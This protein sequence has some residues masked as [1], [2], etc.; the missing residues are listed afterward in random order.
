L[1]RIRRPSQAPA[2]AESPYRGPLLGADALEA[3]ARAL[4]AR[5]TLARRTRKGARRF[6]SRLNE[7]CKVLRQ[8]YQAVAEDV[9][10]GRAILPAAEWLLDNFHLIESQELEVRHNLP[11]SYYLELPKLA[12][13]DYGGAARIY[14][15]ALELIGHSDG[16]LNLDRL[17]RFVA[18]FQTL[19][20]LTIG[21]LWAWPSMLRI[22]LLENL[23]RLADEILQSRA[24]RRQADLFLSEW[25]RREESGKTPVLPEKPP[26]AYVVQLLRHLRE[27][28]SDA[29]ELRRL[30]DEKLVLHDLSPEDAIRAEHQEQATALAAMANTVTSLRFC[31]TLDWSLYFER[32]SLVEQILHR[33][34]AAVYK[35]MDF[36]TRD[37]YRQAVEDLAEPSGEAQV[38]VALRAIESAVLAQERDPSDDRARHVGFHLLGKGRRK[39][40]NDVAYQPALGRRMAAFVFAHATAIYLSAIG[41]L[42]LLAALGAAWA[43]RGAGLAVMAALLAVFPA[44]DLAVSIVQW[45]VTKMIR[46]R[47]LPRLD[48]AGGVPPEGRTMVIIPTLLTS[49]DDVQ[50]LLEH[51]EVQAIGNMDPHIHFAILSDFVDAP[52]A[53]TP[54]DAPILDAARKGIGSLNLRLGNGKNDRFFLFH[55]ARLWNPKE[56]RWM[57]WERKRGKIEEFNRLLRGAGDTSYSTQEGDGSILPQIRFCITLDRDTRL[58][59]DTAKQLIGII[60]HP[61]NRPKLD[62]AQG[63]ITEG[64]GI[65]QPRVSVTFASA[66]GS[67]FSR[68]Y[69]GHTGVD[70]YTTAVS[71]TYQDLFGEGIYTGKGLYDVDAFLAALGDRIPENA[72]L[73]HDLFE[74]LYARTALAS[75]IEVVDDYPSSVVAHMRRQHRWVRGDW[76]ILLWLFPWVPTRRGVERNRLPIISRWK[77]FDNLRRSLVS[78]LMVL[79]LAAGWMIFPGPAWAWTLAVLAIL[80]FPVYP[81][82]LSLVGVP[83]SQQPIRVSL[84]ARREE[85]GT[86]VAQFLITLTFLVYQ[87]TRMVHAIVVTL[88]RLTITKKKLLEWETAASVAA[89]ARTVNGKRALLHF[90]IEV[91]SSPLVAV[92]LAFLVHRYRPEALPQVA[93]LLGLWLAAPLIASWL[94]RPFRDGR[95]AL[96]P[97]D[98]RLL[99]RIARRTWHYFD[100]FAGPA[101]HWLPPDNFQELGDVGVAHRTSPTNIGLSMLSALAACDLGFLRPADLAGRI[102]RMLTTLEGIERFKGHFLN[103]YDTRSLTPLHPRYVSTVDSGNLAGCLLILAQGLREHA[104]APAGAGPRQDGLRDS[105]I[106]FREI[107]E[108]LARLQAS[109]RERTA[110]LA[111]EVDAIGAAG[112]SPA[113]GAPAPALVEARERLHREIAALAEEAAGN[114][115]LGE[116]LHCA[117][118]ILEVAGEDGDAASHASRLLEQSARAE[119]MAN[120][121]DFGF[122]FDAQRKLFTIGYRLPDTEG[123]GRH[124]PTFYDLLA[125]EARL[126]SYIAIS[127]GDVPQI[128]WFHLNRQLVNV[129]GWPTLVSWSAS[130]FEYLMPLLFMKTYPKTLLDQSCRSIVHRQIE[131]ATELGVPWGISESGYNF[132]NR[133]GDYQYKAFGVPGLGLKRGLGDDLVIAPYACAL[134]LAVDPLRATANLRRLAREGVEGRYGFF[135]SIDYTP[136]TAEPGAAAAKHPRS[137]VVVRTYLAHHQGMTLTALANAL[138]DGVMV[139]RFHADPRIQA[140]ELLLQEKMTLAAPISR[141][142][143][144]EE[145]HAPP[146][147]MPAAAARRFRSPH[148]PFPQAHVLSNGNFMSVV[149]NA[150]GGALLGAQRCLTRRRDD[151]TGD[152]GSL[153]LYLRDVRSGLVWSATYQPTGREPEDYKAV[154]LPDRAVFHRRDDGIES[155]LEIAV[156]PEDDMEVRRL[157]LTNMTDRPREIEITSFAEFSLATAAEDLAHPVF[158][159]L[160]LETEYVPSIRSILVGRRSRG[161]SDPEAWGIHVL[162]V[163][164]RLQG[165]VEWETDRSRFIGRGRSPARPVALDGRALSGTTGAVLD[166][167]GSLRLRVRLAPGGFAR[168]AYSTGMAPSRAAALAL[169]ER[170]HDPS[171]AARTL[172]LAYTHAHIEFQHLGVTPEEAQVFLRLASPVF[173]SDAS[174]RATAETL[175]RNELGQPALWR[176]GI[177]GDLPIVLLRILRETDV[178]LVR[179]VLKAQEFWRLKGLHADVVVLNEHPSGYRDEIQKDLSATM[180]NIRWQSPRNLPGGMYL[181]RTDALTETDRIHL[182]ASARVVLRGDR[183]ELTS[184]LSRASYPPPWPANLVPRR[185]HPVAGPN[186]APELPP[187]RFWNGRGGFSE[188]GSQYVIALD[189]E[190]ETPMPWCNILANPDFGTVVSSSG[191]SFTWAENSREN[192]LTPFAN[193]PLSDPTSEAIFLRDEDGGEVWGATPG[194]LPRRPDGGRWIVTQRAGGTRFSHA[195][196]GIRHDLDLF[197]HWEDPVKFSV[198]TIKNTTGE[199]RRLSIFGY[200]EW[201]LGGARAADQ[202]HTVTELDPRRGA[203]LARN[204]FNTEFP[205][206]RAFFA[207]SDPVSSFSCDRVEFIGR[208][209]SLSNPAALARTR[210]SDRQGGGLDPCAALQVRLDLGPG[211]ERQVV[212]VL[213]QGQDAV[214]AGALLERHRSRAAAQ[215]AMAELRRRWDHLL[216]GVEVHTPDDSFDLILNQWLLYQVTAS[217]MWARTGYYQPGGAF[218]FRDQLQDSLALVWSRPE[219]CRSH[220]LLA[221]SRQFL[222]GDVQH[223]WH[224]PAGRGT[225]T[226]CSDDLFWLP[227]A[228]AEYV[229]ATGDQALL[230]VKV[231]FLDAPA[232]E[233]GQTDAY[234]APR[235]ADQS[236]TLY[237]HCIRAVTR[238]LALGAHGLPLIG[239]GDWN[240]GFNRVG[241]AGKGESVWLGWFVFSVLEKMARVA[242]ARNDE[243]FAA[244][245]RTEAERLREKLDLAWDGDW[246]RRA[247]YDDGTALGSAQNDECRIDSI[248]QSWAVLSG[249]APPRRAEQAIDAV[250]AQ[251]I[252]RDARLILLFTPPFDR[253]AQDPGYIKGYIPGIRENGGQYTHAALWTIMAIGAL[254]QG[255]EAAEYFHM[256]NPINRT[257]TPGDSDQYKVEPYVVAADIYAHPMHYGRGGWTWYTGS[258]GWMYRTGLESILGLKRRGAALAVNPCIPASWPEYRVLWRFGRTR[259]EVH[260]ENPE[261]RSRGV[262]RAELDGRAVDAAA[263][264]LVDDGQVHRVKVVLGRAPAEPSPAPLVAQKAE[265]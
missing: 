20:P 85:L 62:L 102:D 96:Q 138:Q 216:S 217:R 93:P 24:A 188:D 200:V 51:L 191:S 218:G 26:T 182:A 263:I 169:A 76:Q 87:A 196:H 35:R 177:S 6:R 49:P 126:A 231:P 254:G 132:V 122:L 238:G 109:A 156:S 214:A 14:I 148:T 197:V 7:Q 84:V 147:G 170:Y 99:R 160:F 162:G 141:P 41:L 152:P 229:E 201:A 223:W 71:D 65:L 105:V 219:L 119:R 221:A 136:R 70:P 59:R 224:P 72:L 190:E 155:Q 258:A 153:F 123:P 37:R 198:L 10:Q 207:C 12:S 127:K 215:T 38:R 175:E 161:G 82:L 103:W 60:L 79:F 151:R 68:V 226:R 174:L 17:V 86:A 211:E 184:Q 131:Y 66:A 53:E 128:H 208:N 194:P 166:P 124:D 133:K 16:H 157:S 9:H 57:G 46:P 246:Y 185:T 39:L 186:P 115:A 116:L 47:A 69:A 212:F 228:V 45:I 213:G 107:R 33:D 78:P 5:F 255:D 259:Y 64:Y 88:V 203:V 146:P 261:K 30:V 150:G 3:R 140:T 81:Q 183:G 120:D 143:P 74:G 192:R 179:Q 1:S 56:N 209:R 257:R 240:D 43:V 111:R 34:P 195:A 40:E 29:T 145:S 154:F 206:R 165:S 52:T 233:P 241:A 110:S 73:S 187:L 90:V 32:V 199:P 230:D 63:R 94:S 168:L 42:T 8:A 252:R 4:A 80:A 236:A 135:E 95:V 89:R 28:G 130:M 173:F 113:D 98:A 25:D 172:S 117:R 112:M 234:A 248:A 114:A 75:D 245:C 15:M 202:L 243:S 164:G 67:L 137:G 260:V 142:R 204:A 54:Q 97:E 11:R 193:D 220:L 265:R 225:R 108:D 235:V 159:K 149:T 251:L 189:G 77:I 129:K 239:S 13:R 250:R 50:G 18:S 44:S 264:P 118:A 134:S 55:R 237:E 61:L 83:A 23:R 100:T 178:P 19:A 253:S 22:A 2:A 158:A 58:P 106:F 121:M 210:L 31:S 227:Y 180:D 163:E 21:E 181:L 176:H 244:R 167:V 27:Y 171:A 144:A 91:S 48:L 36:G 232:L 101:D 247:Y 242:A 104:A 92:L 256:I 139:R 249:A 205:G 262:L 125:S 222:E